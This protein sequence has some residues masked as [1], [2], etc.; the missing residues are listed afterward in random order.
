[1]DPW[2]SIRIDVAQKSIAASSKMSE[3]PPYTF[4]FP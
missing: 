2:F 1:M 3:P 4:T